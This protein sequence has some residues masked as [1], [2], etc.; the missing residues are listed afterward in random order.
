MVG[1]NI[2]A[3]FF[4]RDRG[5]P[6]AV[7][8]TLTNTGKIAGAEVPQL[9]LEDVVCS[10]NRSFIELAGFERIALNPGESR[11]VTFTLTDEQ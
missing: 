3:W 9:Y 2:G 7:T 1:C 5:E 6:V 4:H 8:F 10:V 11:D